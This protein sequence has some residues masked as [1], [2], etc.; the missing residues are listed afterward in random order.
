MLHAMHTPYRI[1]LL[2]ILIKCSYNIA[3][4][5]GMLSGVGRLRPDY[6]VMLCYMPLPEDGT[7]GTPVTILA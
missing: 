7:V 6:Y 3:V 1:I 4:H 2:D 5:G